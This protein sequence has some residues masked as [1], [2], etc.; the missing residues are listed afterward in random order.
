MRGSLDTLDDEIR[1]TAAAYPP[2]S[3][4]AC[5]EGGGTSFVVCISTLDSPTVPT[6]RFECDT[7]TPGETLSACAAFLRG[8]D[9]VA[10]AVAT[11]GPVCLD[12]SSPK[13]GHITSTPKPGWADTD[14]L[15]PLRAASP[16]SPVRFDTDVNAPALAEHLFSGRP[17]STAYVTCG[18]GVGVGLCVNGG[19]VHGAM[20]PEGGHVAIEKLAGDE[21]GG[22]S[23]GA[24]APYGGRCTVEA[25]ASAISVLERL[26]K[27]PKDPRDRAVLKDLA[28]DDE[29]WDHV[30]N[31][32]AGLCVNLVLLTSIERIV[33]SG[34]M[35]LRNGL[36]EKVRERTRVLLNGYIQIPQ[37]LE[38][39]QLE[40]FI[41]KSTW[42][43]NAG[44][45]GALVMAWSCARD[46]V[47]G[48]LGGAKGGKWRGSEV[49]SFA[50]GVVTTLALVM[51]TKLRN[52][53]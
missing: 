7:T 26:G 53:R 12:P 40:Q 37:I 31:A 42:G 5:V 45:V 11:F 9:Y 10:L 16:L 43:N 52:K 20:H 2:G 22:Y 51:L 24:G 23:W 6:S 38:D 49:L 18:T 29:V 48:D 41:C 17:V 44:V 50:A 28:D 47:K 33:L 21:F 15:S 1:E 35:M 32:I 30:A 14:V 19:P 39:D 8:H 3:K 4:I 13:Y 46:A 34:G 27:D 25:F 36:I